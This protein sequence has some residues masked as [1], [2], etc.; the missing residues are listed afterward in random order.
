MHSY[1]YYIFQDD[2]FGEQ[3]SQR[4]TVTDIKKALTE[5]LKEAKQRMSVQRNE[6]MLDLK[7][8][9]EQLSEDKENLKNTIENAFSTASHPTHTSFLQFG[10]DGRDALKGIA[11]LNENS[12]RALITKFQ[13]S[14]EKLPGILEMMQNLNFDVSCV[15]Q[16]LENIDGQFDEIYKKLE[17]ECLNNADWSEEIGKSLQATV[18]EWNEKSSS[19]D[20]T[21]NQLT[22][23][24]RSIKDML[25]TLDN[26]L[27]NRPAGT[28]DTIPYSPSNGQ[29]KLNRIISISELESDDIGDFFTTVQIC[30]DKLAS[31]KDHIDRN[32]FR[33]RQSTELLMDGLQLLTT[34]VKNSVE[35]LKSLAI[36]MP[37][38]EDQLEKTCRQEQGGFCGDVLYTIAEYSEMPEES[39]GDIG[40]RRS[41]LKKISATDHRQKFGYGAG[42][43]K[44]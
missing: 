5:F 10:N 11:V 39:Q 3:G 35:T 40:L 18:K 42:H 7:T 29:Y 9:F 12:E 25:V 4:S 19:M 21:C 6:V 23:A 16:T 26:V 38:S 30:R 2:A 8:V 1:H 34:L 14:G 41:K 32:T 28:N 22:C 33:V 43:T 20:E 15:K 27:C 37:D 13:E 44:H 31:M 17:L 36:K 24:T